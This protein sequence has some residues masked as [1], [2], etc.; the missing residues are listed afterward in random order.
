MM[1][2]LV[3]EYTGGSKVNVIAYS[4]GSPIAR[5]VWFF[6]IMPNPV[7]YIKLFYTFIIMIMTLNISIYQ[8][9]ILAIILKI[10]APNF[11]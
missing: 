10:F 4:M 9:D 3:A 8:N 2:L 5:K 6:K 7:D 11:I 1:I